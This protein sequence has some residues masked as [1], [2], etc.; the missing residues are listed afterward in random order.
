MI[1]KLKRKYALS[2]RG[3]ADMIKACFCVAFTNIVLML[4][5]AVLYK[6]IKDMMDD[7]LSKSKLP[8]YL[9]M[10]PA[11]IILM[12]VAHYIQYN[13][14]FLATYTE[15][16][17]RRI[18]LAEKIRK[19]PHS[20]FGKKDLTDLT[21]TMMGDCTQVETAASHW[22]P[23]MIGSLIST[24]VISAAM[25]IFFDWRMALAC[26]WVVPVSFFAIWL[27]SGMRK[28]PPNIIRRQCLNWK[29]AFRN[30]WN[31]SRTSVLTIIRISI[32]KVLIKRSKMLK[33]RHS[34]LR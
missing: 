18:S 9:I 33:S 28:K 4:P 31:Q 5:V 25:F 12:A 8:M 32:W 23:E 22:I 29:K 10:C 30:V 26:F 16:G 7:A 2:D 34:M 20:F 14:S 17:V 6:L 27:S 24:V 13:A 1:E 15:S 11:V 3:A 21:T 19:L